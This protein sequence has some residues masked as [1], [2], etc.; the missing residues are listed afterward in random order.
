MEDEGKEN[1]NGDGKEAGGEGDQQL[2]Q[3]Q[4]KLTALESENKTLKDAKSDL[5]QRLDEADKELLSDAYLDYKEKVSKVKSSAH[6]EGL[7]IDLD[8]ASNREIAAFIEK[9]YK[10]DMDAAI[11]DI[12]GQ[13]DLTKQQMSIIA[14]QFDIALAEIRYDGRDGKPSFAKNRDAI[15]KIAKAN[16]RWSAEECYR[17][18]V[19]ENDANVREKSERDRRKAEEEEKAATERAGVPGSSVHEKELTA[20]EAATIAYRKAFGNKV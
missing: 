19:L 16:P 5:E 10:G 8:R 13:L 12:K 7:D 18:F 1:E 4:S 3:L 20:E 17:Q 15:F 9:K 14:A 11:R 6:E 2:T